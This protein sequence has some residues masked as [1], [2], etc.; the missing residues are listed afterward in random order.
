[1][2]RKIYVSV[3]SLSPTVA[4]VRLSL[5]EPINSKGQRS[6]QSHPLKNL[7]RF[8]FRKAWVTALKSDDAGFVQKTRRLITQYMSSTLDQSLCSLVEALTHR[9]SLM[10]LWGGLLPRARRVL[11]HSRPMRQHYLSLRVATPSFHPCLGVLYS[12]FLYDEST[13][14]SR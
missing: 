6:A 12:G 1:V 14:V 8:P 13:K 9:S 4:T 3:S 2:F 10:R 5:P 7:H 11:M